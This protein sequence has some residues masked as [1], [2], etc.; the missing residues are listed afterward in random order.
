MANKEEAEKLKN[1]ANKLF[2]GIALFIKAYA[3]V[4]R[5]VH[6]YVVIRLL[7]GVMGSCR[8]ALR[9]SCQSVHQGHRSLPGERSLLCKQVVCAYKARGVWLSSSRR[10]QGH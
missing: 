9:W 1:E 5:C 6:A 7:G 2:K 4:M 8:E 3:G 10:Q